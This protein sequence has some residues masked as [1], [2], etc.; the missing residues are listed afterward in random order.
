MKNGCFDKIKIINDG[1]NSE[2]VFENN[3]KE[4]FF[5]SKGE[6]EYNGEL[7]I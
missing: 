4:N 1:G 7:E 3:Y 6:I 5:L 2:V